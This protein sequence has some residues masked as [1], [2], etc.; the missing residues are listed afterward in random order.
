M[1]PYY[2][3]RVTFSPE[4]IFGQGPDSTGPHSGLRSLTVT[5]GQA[6]MRLAAPAIFAFAFCMLSLSSPAAAMW[7]CRA[8]SG[9]GSAVT[10]GSSK[11]EAQDTVLADCAARSQRFATCRIVSCKFGFGRRS[12]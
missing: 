1:V 9:S 2:H 12:N 11:K 3:S 4:I 10:A 5:R 6:M 7:T 8:E